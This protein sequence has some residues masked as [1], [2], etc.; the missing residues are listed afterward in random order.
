MVGRVNCYL[1]EDDPL[2][3]VDTGPNSGKALDE[4][5]LRLAEHG[6]RVEDLERIVVS[7]HHPDHMGLLEILARRSGADV[8]ALD[9]VA[10]VLADFP[11]AAEAD[12]VLAE[13][14]MLRHGVDRNVVSVLRAVSRAYRAWGSSAE[15][16][17]PLTDGGRLEFANR[18]WE[19]HH[20]PGH[21]PSDTIF[22][23]ARRGVLYCADH[24]IEK[25]SS[26]PLIQTPLGGPFRSSPARP[27]ALTTY[28]E[29]LRTT[30]EM[31]DVEIAHSG[32]GDPIPHFRELIDSRLAMHEKRAARILRIITGEPR[33]A[34][35]IAREMWRDLAFTQA[36]L[37]I[38]EVLGH[39]DLLLERGEVVEDDRDGVSVFR[40]S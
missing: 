25:I 12:D 13:E 6:R 5:E 30:R 10:P 32:H 4:L 15:V 26:V 22:H 33:T 31:E 29:S 39:L 14:L 38:C 34:H 11:A 1:V 40:S 2:T 36:Y 28:I 20:R 21:S 9:L 35:Q 23:D 3:L 17:R 8:C 37:T 19:I 27:M 7:H 24:L 16:T 18:T